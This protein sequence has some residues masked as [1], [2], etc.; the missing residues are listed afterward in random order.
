MEDIQEYVQFK[1]QKY[2][3]TLKKWNVNIAE[4]CKKD[5][6]VEVGEITLDSV[7][8]RR[9]AKANTVTLLCCTLQDAYGVWG[10]LFQPS[11]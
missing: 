5:G 2:L 8:R 7:E 6:D 11:L 1:T 4:Y 3:K 10:Y 9:A